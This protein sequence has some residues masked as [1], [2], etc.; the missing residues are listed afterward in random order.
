VTTTALGPGSDAA[1]PELAAGT[2]A[3]L[4][5][6]LRRLVPAERVLTR[7]IDLVRFASDASLYRLIPKVVVVA[8]DATEVAALFGYS[9][10]HRVPMTFRSAGTSLSG[11]SLTDG[12]LV[13]VRRHF[14]RFSVL[15]D[16]AAVRSGPGVIAGT[17][18][19]AL[20][21]RGRKLGPDPASVNAAT[22]GGIVAN[23][24]SG[25]CCGITDNAYQTMRSIEFVLPSGTRIDTAEPDAEATF[26]AC[27]P[28]LAATL[29][30]LRRRLL[31]DPELT[32]TLRRKYSVKNTTGYG[33]NALLDHETPLAIFSHLLVGSE[34]TLAFIAQVVLETV[35]DL[36][37]RT[38]ALVMFPTIRY[39]CEA[40][41]AFRTAG[42]AA[43]E[44][45]DRASLQAVADRPGV[46]AGLGDLPAGTAALL[47]EMR[48][49]SAAELATATAAVEAATSD[50]PI[51]GEVEFTADA[52]RQREYW[53]VREGLFTSVGAARPTNTSVVLEDVTFPPARL[54][55]GVAELAAL[56]LAHGYPDAV[57]F[58]HAKEGN[59]H[60]LLT[61]RFDDPDEIERYAGF[62]RAMVELVAVRYGGSLKGEHGTGRN[63]APFVLT[64]WGPVATGM[65]RSIKQ[66]ADPDG[67]LN[68]GVI[69]SDDPD[70]FLDH[71][72]SAPTIEVEAD[73]CIECGYCE[74]VCPSRDL[75]TTPRQR[76]VI[77]REMVRQ[78]AVGTPG[79]TAMADALARDIDYDVRDT[80]AGDGLCEMACPVDIDTGALVKRLRAT[81][82]PPAEHRLA[83]AAARHWGT[84]ERLTRTALSAAATAARVGSPAVVSGATSAIRR[85]TGDLL[86]PNW[87]PATPSAAPTLP[88]TDAG[89]AVAVYFPACVNRMFGPPGGDTEL[90]A[91]QALVTLAARAAR[92][93]WIP[94]D[95]AGACC[96]TPWVSKGYPAGAATMAA[97]TLDRA[98]AWTDA[99]RLPL[100]TDASSCALGLADLGPL[101]DDDRR[102][103]FDAITVLDSIDFVHDTVLPGLVER[104]GWTR[105]DDAIVVH[106]TCSVQHAHNVDRLLAI[107]GAV[108]TNVLTPAAGSCCGFAGDRGFWRP[109]LT[110]SATA[111]L[112]RELREHE[113]GYGAVADRV[114]SN[115]PCEIGL[116]DGTGSVFGSYLRLLE[117]RTRLNDKD[118]V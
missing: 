103:R 118:A 37:H 35:P 104:G 5:D 26:A 100:V 73:R 67:M 7:P 74:R 84:A 3:G 70:S 80:C 60:F 49:A 81:D 77:R 63:M 46:P 59:L 27:E 64:E 43:V 61:P 44:L 30:E 57:V 111:G 109:E 113:A 4:A 82:H 8:A 108:T 18:N 94:P 112:S 88:T 47:V 10:S 65:M 96:T 114:S 101:L 99:G 75:T 58:G 83:N 2:P 31:D 86:V 34:G 85:L 95:V 71:L 42:A 92:P 66:A 72:K 40:V 93:L 12:I 33:L 22:V 19:A 6:D 76:I 79:A 23:N 87:T 38:T 50:M 53:A 16:G 13:E 14:D 90:S 1:P 62:M 56:F 107:V 17:V 20:A 45:L 68:P 51:L 117:E 91:P 78:L 29:T 39:A 105:S 110:A 21:R 69:L 11:Q 15:E 115:R 25:M 24:S 48:T 102:A 52:S 9:R 28:A 55:E 54:A 32:A 89:G 98:W 106:A 116:S 97:I 36:R 41:A